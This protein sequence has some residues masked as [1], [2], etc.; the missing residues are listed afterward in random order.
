MKTSERRSTCPINYS[1]EIFGDKWMFLILRDIMFNG[2]NSFLEFRASDEKISSAVLTEKLNL[3]LEEGIVSKVT[4]PKNASKF[5][6]LITEKGIELV[7]AMVEFLDWGSR[8]NPDGGPKTWLERIR[9]NKKKAIMELQDK[10]REDRRSHE[11]T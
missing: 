7:P 10:L 2:K 6:Y 11:L 5:L 8:Y 4:S 9:Q 1:V 3:L